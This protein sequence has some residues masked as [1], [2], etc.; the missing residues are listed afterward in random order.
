MAREM[1]DSGI[2]WVDKTPKT[3]S[4]SK[5]KYHY[6]ITSGSGFKDSLQ[7]KKNGDIP[8]CKASDIS[9]A[10]DLLNFSSNYL[11]KRE[12]FLSGFSLIPKGS[13]VF[14]KIGEAMKKNN[15]SLITVD[16]GL[17]N[18]CQGLYSP[19][20]N[21]YYSLCLFKCI[22]MEW[23][24]NGGTI[25]SLSN[26]KLK[27][28]F[29]PLPPKTEQEMIAKFLNTK[30]SEIDSLVADIIKEIELL[31]EYRKSVIYEAVT[32]GLDPNVEM[33]DSG[34]EW[35]GQIPTHWKTDNPKYYFRQ[36]T[37]RA[38]PGMKQYTASQKYG[39]IPQSEYMEITGSKI[40]TVGHGFDILKLVCKGDF[41]IH[42]RSFQGGLEY[43][44]NTGSISSAY[45]MVTPNSP[46]IHA[47][48][49]RWHFKATHYID[50]ISMTSNLIRDGQ[51]MRW[52][53][54]TSVPICIPSPLE[55]Q[56][57]ANYLDSKC[58]EIDSLISDKQQQIEKLTEYKKSLIY[59]Y[60]TGKKE[61]PAV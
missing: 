32:K 26:L 10:G 27:N 28:S 19:D 1:K 22:N 11:D 60:V 23:F 42:M 36:R 29:I 21:N 7:G 30:C 15:R 50:A 17:D 57:I 43:S 52:S 4:I 16:C 2:E 51:A 8:I 9:K 47:D 46:K 49:Y 58:S 24:D 14:P 25:P 12:F 31:K 56:Q 53:N 18:N 48:Y 45:V 3:W 35:I 41:V 13:I 5:I 6:S 55:Q 38:K 33:K 37:D 39:V 20:I 40:V 59:E 34:I 54:F 61:V 44:F